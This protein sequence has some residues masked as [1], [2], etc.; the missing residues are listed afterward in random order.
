MLEYNLNIFINTPFFYNPI[1]E[2]KNQNQVHIQS[3]RK[4]TRAMQMVSAAKMRKAQNAALTSRT[5]SD[6]A[7]GLIHSLAQK[8]T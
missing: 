2:L 4:I 3:T 6:M 8:P 5:Y 1:R 7:W